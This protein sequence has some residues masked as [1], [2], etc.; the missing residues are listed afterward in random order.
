V[1][2]TGSSEPLVYYFHVHD[3]IS[4][5][6]SSECEQYSFYLDLQLHLPLLQRALQSVTITTNV[7]SL[8][9]IHGEVYL[10]QIVVIKFVIDLLQ[11]SDFLHQ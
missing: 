4:L 1:S 10:M 11:V 7:M 8:N 5:F 6:C 9:P 3:D 2:D